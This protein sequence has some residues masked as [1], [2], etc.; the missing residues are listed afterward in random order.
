MGVVEKDGLR[1]RGELYEHVL[2]VMVQEEYGSLGGEDS[3]E[4]YISNGNT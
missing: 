1:I 4:E 3:D 2:F